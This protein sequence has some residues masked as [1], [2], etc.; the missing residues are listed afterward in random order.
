MS[1]K[2]K[3]NKTLLGF[4][5][6]ISAIVALTVA[7]ILV[8]VIKPEDPPTQEIEMDESGLVF[9]IS[10]DGTQC[11]VVDIGM[12]RDL[13]VEIPSTYKGL[14][15]TAIGDNA[16]ANCESICE[17]II[18]DSVKAIGYSAFMGCINLEKISVP[19]SIEYIAG[20][21]FNCRIDQ[22]SEGVIVGFGYTPILTEY[23]NALYIG[24]EE[25]KYVVLVK[26]K[27]TDIESCIIHPDTRVIMCGAFGDCQKLGSIEIPSSVVTIGNRAFAYCN[28]LTKLALPDSVKYVD[29]FAFSNC[30]SLV[31]VSVGR[32]VEF[33]GSK[34]FE[35]CEN[36]KMVNIT[37]IAAW[38]QIDFRNPTSNMN[39][40]VESNPLTFG[41]NLYMNDFALVNVTIPDGVTKISAYAFHRNPARVI[42]PD[43]GGAGQESQ[44]VY[45]GPISIT[46]PSSVK[47]IGK[48]AFWGC[49]G[50]T[51]VNVDSLSSWL[52]IKFADHAANPLFYGKLYIDNELVRDIVIPKDI[53]YIPDYSMFGMSVDS[54]VLHDGV[55]YIGKDVFADFTGVTEITLNEGLTV[56]ATGAFDNSGIIKMNIPSSLRYFPEEVALYDV[57]LHFNNLDDFLNKGFAKAF[58]Q[59]NV[60]RLLRGY[61]L[62]IGGEKI[63]DLE[64]PEGITEIPDSLLEGCLT[65]RS[66]KIPSSVLSIGDRAFAACKELT[67]V[68]FADGT[69]VERI[70]EAAFALTSIE[71][72]V[73]PD[74]VLDLGKSAFAFCEK[75]KTV[76]LPCGLTAISESLFMGCIGLT[77]FE[78]PNNITVIE[79]NAFSTTGL[80]TVVIPDTV[81]KVGTG[82][83]TK[84]EA[85]ESA[86]IGNGV[87]DITAPFYESSLKSLVIGD[88]VTEFRTLA[89]DTM[90]ELEEVTIGRGIT[91]LRASDFLELESLCSITFVNTEGWT[92]KNG[93]VID[94]ADPEN[95]VELF[96]SDPRLVLKCNG[97]QE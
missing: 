54:I 91:M 25:N 18:P 78:I 69:A 85:L 41:G 11:A 49:T 38:C 20:I 16:F 21:P 63:V 29:E 93:N 17:L 97:T 74:S 76:Q 68:E 88:G 71:S 52:S 24:N 34:A 2:I 15:V 95:N 57:E 65:I 32:G 3:L 14:P 13:V 6:C 86:V 55:E 96:L 84:C 75:L 67:S 79:K 50:L 10:P 5:A 81:L 83:F 58:S 53:K 80:K 62:Y 30:K 28:S 77:E 37:D 61:H 56:V 12:C 73:L 70:G 92:D 19:D 87:V 51:K 26:A 45:L 4:I 72:L 66:V 60:T 46:I 82:A 48:G 35:N 23:D 64:I 7:L 36:I 90:K 31:R 1:S 43:I 8:I 40:Y 9:E 59:Y 22:G 33:F 27:S 94:V 42:T 44:N 89:I 39:G 47:E